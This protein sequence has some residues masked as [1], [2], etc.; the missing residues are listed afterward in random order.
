MTKPSQLRVWE[1]LEPLGFPRYLISNYAEVR[2]VGA[3]PTLPR[4]T[5]AEGAVVL[6]DE[7]GVKRCR[8]AG[9]L[10]R[11]VFG[12]GAPGATVS[13]TKLSPEQVVEIRT[14]SKAPTVVAAD[15]GVSTSTIKAVRARKTHKSVKGRRARRYRQDRDAIPVAA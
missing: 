6:V 11:E 4:A 10:C 15:L 8:A 5:N 14:N 13:R 7:G 1:S 3:D 12:P 2:L 9:K